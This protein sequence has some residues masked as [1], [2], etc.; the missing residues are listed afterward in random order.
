MNHKETMKLPFWIVAERNKRKEGKSPPSPCEGGDVPGR[1]G[2][3]QVVECKKYCR[4]SYFSLLIGC[5]NEGRNHKETMKLPLWMVVERNK[6]K[7]G[8]GLPK[9]LQRRGCAWRGRGRNGG[10]R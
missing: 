4:T 3:Q 7:G 5:F 10:L 8:W 9:P 1:V 2:L 6:G